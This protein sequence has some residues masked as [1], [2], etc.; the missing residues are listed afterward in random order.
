MKLTVEEQTDRFLFYVWTTDEEALGI[1]LNKDRMTPV[2]VA[3]GLRALA[4]QTASY[5]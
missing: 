5:G 1:S 4:T 3:S 2:T